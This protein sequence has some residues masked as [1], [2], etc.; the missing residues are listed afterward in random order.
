MKIDLKPL[1]ARLALAMQAVED[2]HEP[3]LSIAFEVI[4]EELLDDY[5]EDLEE[6]EE[7]EEDEKSKE[8]ESEDD[9]AEEEELEEEEPKVEE[10]AKPK[11]PQ[12]KPKLTLLPLAESLNVPRKSVE[13]LFTLNQEG[14]SFIYPLDHI[15]TQRGKTVALFRALVYTNELLTHQP[16]LASTVIRQNLT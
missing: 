9:E 2:L 15:K 11:K 13:R 14:L 16:F 12:P 6:E 4:L 7:S 5:F 8:D 1:K 3:Y 10:P